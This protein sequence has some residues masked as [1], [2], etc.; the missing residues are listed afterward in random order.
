LGIVGLFDTI[1]TSEDYLRGKPHPDPFLEAARRL[2]AVPEQCLVFEDTQ[3]G[4]QAATAAGMACV[5][6]PP[7]QR[8][9]PGR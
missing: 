6:I 1:V 5:L 3:T 7:L 8:S 9:I 4:I 2:G